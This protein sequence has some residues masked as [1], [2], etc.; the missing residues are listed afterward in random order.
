MS[1]IIACIVVYVIALCCPAYA[2]HV[3]VATP[4]DGQ[5]GWNLALDWEGFNTTMGWP[6]HSCDTGWSATVG[7]TPV[8]SSGIESEPPC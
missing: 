5:S 1:P 4:I 2:Q 7:G 3:N 6:P 8:F